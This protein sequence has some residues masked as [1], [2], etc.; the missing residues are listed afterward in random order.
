MDDVQECLPFV[1]VKDVF[2]SGDALRLEGM[3][4]TPG[5]LTLDTDFVRFYPKS[6]T[7]VWSIQISCVLEIQRTLFEHQSRGI[8][9]GQRNGEAALFAFGA[10][11]LQQSF[12]EAADRLG[13]RVAPAEDIQEITRMWVR[14][15]LSNFQYLLE[16]NFRSGR[17]WSNYAQ[18]PIFPWTTD[19]AGPRRDLSFPY[20]AQSEEQRE[21]CVA[22]F[23]M[24]ECHYPG[25]ISHIATPLYFLVRVEPFA[26]AEIEFMSGRFDL[27]ARTF[28]SMEAASDIMKAVGGR[29]VQELIPEMYFVP[30]MF[31]NINELD[32][33][34]EVQI[35]SLPTGIKSHEHLVRTL[36][37][38]LES[39]EVSANLHH[40]IDLIWGVRRQGRHAEERLNVVDANAFGFDPTEFRHDSFMLEAMSDRLHN[41]GQAPR[42][43]FTD[44]H[45]R[46][47]APAVPTGVVLKPCA[48]AKRRA[49]APAVPSGD[50][51][52]P[53]GAAKRRSTALTDSLP[54]DLPRGLV[55]EYAVVSSVNDHGWTLAVHQLPMVSV[56]RGRKPCAVLRG[57][58]AP[59]STMTAACDAG[60]IAVGHADGKI[61]LFSVDPFGFL[62]VIGDDASESVRMIRVLKSELCILSVK[63]V[64]NESIVTLWSVNGARR[65]QTRIPGSVVEW[66]VTNFAVGVK[67]N[68]AFCLTREGIVVTL[69]VPSLKIAEGGPLCTN[70]AS[71]AFDGVTL[72][73][74]TGTGPLRWQLE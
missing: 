37:K 74:E 9:V 58:L 41:F 53:L 42:Q 16:L 52:S 69:R 13:L 63:H 2:F 56:W 22:D 73:V 19:F 17:S 62:R 64:E 57:H 15:Q 25:Y 61:S 18:F 26:S 11:H 48:L 12:L 43:L 39:P 55:E 33:A 71:L 35:V 72:T 70:G 38:L 7:S 45:P 8:M 4:V 30:E 27:P 51:L 29:T 44:F 54:P 50:V 21:K 28:H 31:D 59:I 36:R 24:L 40:W 23:E 60:L 5:L 66:A 49:T 20:F 32:L 3:D 47:A 68:L 14:G 10:I 6:R 34:P 46:R 1:A 65:S 67:K